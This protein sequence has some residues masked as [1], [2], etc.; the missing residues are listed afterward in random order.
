MTK[1]F[2]LIFCVLF[3]LTLWS[4][5]TP[6]WSEEVSLEE[7]LPRPDIYGHGID[8]ERI[9]KE[10]YVHALKWPV[11]VTGLLVPYE[12]LKYFL[13]GTKD[14]ALHRL[15]EKIGKKSLGF[16]SLDEMYNWLGLNEYPNVSSSIDVF[17]IPYPEQV[18]PDYRMGASIIETK[19]GKGLTFAC[20]TCH[21]GT[22]MGRSVM[23]LT[24]KR[25]RANEFFVMAKKYIPYIPSG[26]FKAGTNATTQEKRMFKRTKDNLKYVGA[27]APRVLGLD[28]SLPHVA[29]SLDKR[30]DDDIASKVRTYRSERHPLYTMPA[31]SK[32]M[33]WWNLKY[34]TRWLSDGSIIQ[35]NPVLTN[36]LW[37]ELGR[38]TDLVELEKWMRDNQE[39]I[40]DLTA[41]VFATSAPHWTDF[42]PDHTIDLKKAKR[43]E[44]VFVNSCQS[45]HGQYIKNWSLSGSKNKPYTEQLKTH[46]VHYHKKTPVIDIGTDPNRYLATKYFASKLNNLK[47]S[48]WMK[49]VV[50]PQKGY[51]PPPLEGIFL[52]YPYMH[53]NSIPNLCALMMHPDNRPV[54]FVQGPANELSDYDQECLGYPVGGKI[55]LAWWKDKNAVYRAGTPGLS[56]QGHTKAF[57]DK[58]GKSIMNDKEKSDLLEFLKTL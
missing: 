20:A 15:V 40:D 32:P 30:A 34:K 23:G 56:N 51:V 3:S 31:D 54:I 53:N 22:F 27:V 45:C 43:G 42:F 17:H 37:N 6:D 33:P 14:S 9:K 36:F 58:E 7:G 8:L 1:A 57:W 19:H 47:I 49:T 29:L 5:E 39:S 35:G 21:S 28:T 55:P 4:Y 38:G 13:E 18:F 12:P 44:K 10:G 24:N 48:K 11:K 25:P 46:K 52:R 2:P 41:A 26:V 50:V 16:E